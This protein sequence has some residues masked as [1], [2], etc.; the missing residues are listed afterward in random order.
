MLFSFYISHVISSGRNFCNVS[1]QKVFAEYFEKC[2]L[3]FCL[4]YIYIYIVKV[5]L[6]SAWCDTVLHIRR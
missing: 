3:I 4:I 1:L 5:S 6:I 2:L